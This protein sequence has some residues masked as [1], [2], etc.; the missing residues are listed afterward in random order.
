MIPAEYY[1]TIYLLVVLFMTMRLIP[2]YTAQ[3]VCS[4]RDSHLS[5]SVAGFYLTVLIVVFIGFRPISNVFYDTV[6][7]AGLYDAVSDGDPFA[8]MRM[9]DFNFIYTPLLVSCSMGGIPLEGFLLLISSIYFGCIFV[10]CKKIFPNDTL[11][12]FLAYLGAFST[13]SYATN[14]IKAGSA[15]SLFLVAVAYKD[16]LKVSIPFLVLSLGF[17]HAMIVPLVSFVIAFFIKKRKWFLYGWMAC[18]IMA[19]LHITVFMTFFAGSTDEHAAQYLQEG[20]NVSGFRPDFILY[21]AIP[22]FLGNHLINKY[23]IKSSYY[24][25]LW[26]IYTIANSVFLLCTYGNFINRIA[27]LSWLLYPIVLLYPFLN[28]FWSPN[29]EKY[30][31][32]TVW[33][34]LG[35]TLFMVFIYYA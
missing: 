26:S 8:I 17:H 30:L 21:S 11:L 20:T 32:Y 1:E 13:F 3:V 23:K 28:I 35:F 27:Y 15:A 5:K 9:G 14:G 7:V 24:D 25:F 18:L 33:G 34:H 6:A 10:A 16:K 31:K 2:L 12:V 29:Q 19:A 4:P 22:I